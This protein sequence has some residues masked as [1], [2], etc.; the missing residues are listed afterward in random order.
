MILPC[1]GAARSLIEVLQSCHICEHPAECQRAGL[2]QM[3]VY[4]SRG[5]AKTDSAVFCPKGFFFA[6]LFNK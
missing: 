4:T 3:V 1:A 2:L 6:Y 5:V